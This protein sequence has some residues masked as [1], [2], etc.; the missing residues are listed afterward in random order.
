MTASPSP[1][2]TV[3]E[4]SPTS[5][6]VGIDIAKESFVVC[7][8]PTGIT[9]SFPQTPAGYAAVI[10]W[11]Q[12]YAISKIVLE[13]TGGYEQDLLL[14]LLE[15]GLPTASINPRQSHHARLT[16][17]QLDKT[18][19]SDAEVLAWMAEHIRSRN[20]E[21]TSPKLLELKELVG[22]RAQLV[23]MKT[24][25]SNR[26][27]QALQ[28]EEQ[29]SLDRHLKF[30]MREIKQLE[31][32]IAQRVQADDEWRQAARLLQS[33]PGVGPA[34]SHLLISELPELGK[35]NRQEISALVGVAPRAVQSGTYDGPRHI[36]GGR[37]AVRSALYMAT[38][39][40]IRC[41]EVIRGHYRHLKQLGK[42]TKVA[43]TACMRKVLMI[44][45]SMLKTNQP[46]RLA[47]AGEP[48]PGTTEQG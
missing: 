47:T 21:P 43:I 46:W 29:R 15:A 17:H 18:D 48:L 34:T 41:N 25:E 14:A 30:L 28:R 20:A 23:R 45:N 39:S 44:L 32:A 31:A 24:A 1:N 42:K 37:T 36:R 4:T 27:Q 11:L 10:A 9:R 40:A 33:M 2:V 19:H 6:Y 5:Y 26:R 12:S 13:A 3:P 16:L 22:R 8:M 7:L 35:A 38:L